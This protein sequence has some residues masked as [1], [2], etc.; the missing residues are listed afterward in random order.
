MVNW[1][2]KKLRKWLG[3][4]IM[5]CLEPGKI[6]WITVPWN[7]AND[8]VN[9]Q[10]LKRSLADAEKEFDIRFFITAPDIEIKGPIST[11]KIKEM[12]DRLIELKEDS[13]E[14][15]IGSTIYFENDVCVIS[16]TT[17]EKCPSKH[18]EK[19]GI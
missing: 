6:Y 7:L 13:I 15:K 10:D 11:E 8:P 1:I 14:S 19:C 9:Y 18:K 2:K 4:Q 17:C 3:Y 16:G 12:K 5:G